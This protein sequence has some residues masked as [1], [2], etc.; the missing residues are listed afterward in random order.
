MDV[1][2]VGGHGR[3]ARRLARLLV[4]RGDRVRGLIRNSDHARD[5]R[6]D[7]S[8]PVVCDVESA[9]AEQLALAIDGADAVV[10][11]AGAGS[12]SG[13]ERKWT[14]DRDGAIK[15]IEA[16]R[17]DAIDRYV[18]ISSLGAENPPSADDVFS[19]YLRAKAEA[20]RA[21]VDSGLDWTIVRPGLLADD[22]GRG[23]VQ[24]STEPFRSNVPRDD[25]AAVLAAT[26]HEPRS[27]QRIL[28]VG[29]GDDRIEEA[30]AAA[31]T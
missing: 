18:M 19:V 2:I 7:G 23:R 4:A 28:Y 17:A 26:V 9:S 24:I 21:L 13:P 12:G 11:A 27:V 3:V 16:A 31:L 1:A 6:D 30:L 14:I 29:A 22:P 25:V 8:E 20:D 10:F 5:L 15:L